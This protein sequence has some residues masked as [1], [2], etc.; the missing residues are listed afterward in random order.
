MKNFLRALRHAW[1]YRYRFALSV[2]CAALAALLWGLNFTCIYPVLKLLIDTKTPQEWV[3]S[4]V[5]AAQREVDRLEGEAKLKG[6]DDAALEALPPDRHI[7]QQRHDLAGDLLRIERK[8]AAA[9][10]KL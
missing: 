5:D 4:Y 10:S 1:P 6:K 8:L 3:E 9:R 2:A 7:V